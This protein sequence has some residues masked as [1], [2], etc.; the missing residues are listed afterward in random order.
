M[1][2]VYCIAHFANGRTHVEVMRRQ[3]IMAA[4]DAAA[5]KNSNK[6]PFTWTGDFRGEMYRKTCLRR[7]W[8]FWPHTDE[9]RAEMILRAMSRTDPVD[10]GEPEGKD[11]QPQSLTVRDDDVQKMKAVL[12]ESGIPDSAH[13][14]WLKGLA[15]AMGFR[16]ITALPVE[17]IGEAMERLEARAKKVAQKRKGE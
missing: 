2:H 15:S 1:T 3:E 13:K 14:S 11:D 12:S 10:F 4:K 5:R 16:T 7:A 8:K 9:R 17:R 6:V